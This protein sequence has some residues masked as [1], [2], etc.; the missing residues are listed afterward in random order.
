MMIF[1]FHYGGAHSGK[2]PVTLKNVTLQMKIM[3][4]WGVISKANEKELEVGLRWPSRVLAVMKNIC[5]SW[6]R[7]L[8]V[9]K[10]RASVND[11]DRFKIM[12]AKIKVSI[13]FQQ[14][15]QMTFFRYNRV[16]ICD[17]IVTSLSGVSIDGRRLFAKVASFERKEKNVDKKVDTQE[18]NKKGHYTVK[19]DKIPSSY[20]EVVS[21]IVPDQNNQA[22]NYVN[23]N[24]SRESI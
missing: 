15:D 2:L 1:G 18:T 19:K 5:R 24:L 22:K 20:A 14:F 9:Q 23:I 21:G 10:K 12:L 16:I 17:D 6:G 13:L 4:I 8:I 11:F 3:K 7:K